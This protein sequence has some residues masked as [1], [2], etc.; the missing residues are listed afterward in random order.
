MNVFLYFLKVA[1]Q[2]LGKRPGFTFSVISTM[3][4]TL[5]ALFCVGGLFYF[6]V[7]KPLPYQDQDLLYKVEKVQIDKLGLPNVK[8]YGY[9]SLVHLYKNQSVFSSVGI[10]HY[11]DEVLVS[12]PSQPKVPTAYVTPDFFE[13]LGVSTYLG[14]LFDD[15]EK[16]D[17]FI[18][19]AIISYN[20]WKTLF[21]SDPAVIGTDVSV[22][23]RSFN[24]IGVMSPDFIE[25][26]LEGIGRM[27]WDFNPTPE[28]R[29]TR[30]G[31]RDNPRV[32]IGKLNSDTTHEQATQ[33]L[34]ALV[35]R[36]WREKVA[37]IPFYKGWR[38]EIELNSFRDVILGESQ[39]VAYLLLACAISLVFIAIANVS[40]LFLSRAFQRK[41]EFEKRAGFVLMATYG[42]A[43]KE[44][45]NEVFEQFFPFLIYVFL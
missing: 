37:D 35:D 39:L 4:V 11:D 14:R 3:S 30:W 25:P 22:R 42:F 38:I 2:G 13:T 17:S 26:E 44:A 43:D 8:A 27:P 10:A 12:H 7:L 40:N 45:S 23:G 18:P 36:T 28:G 33:A 19:S 41:K 16:L 6:L 15:S 34:T 32:F 31:D 29:R 24:L 20:A 1:W 9:A 5:G 21:N